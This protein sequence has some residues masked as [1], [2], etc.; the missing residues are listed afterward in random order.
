MFAPSDHIESVFQRALVPL[1]PSCRESN[2]SSPIMS[3]HYSQATTAHSMVLF[4]AV[5][6]ATVAISASFPTEQ[7]AR[8]GSSIQQPLP[9]SWSFEQCCREKGLE[10]L[11]AG[12]P[13]DQDP[14]LSSGVPTAMAE[15]LRAGKLFGGNRTATTSYLSC[16]VGGDT[17]SPTASE[18]CHQLEK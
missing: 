2:R 14:L 8:N 15:R 12:A 17:L 11:D 7:L 5:L 16:A 13:C 4:C 9:K 6:T 10:G 18:C 1:Q 3:H